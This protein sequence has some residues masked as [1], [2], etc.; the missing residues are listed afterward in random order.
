MK[1]ETLNEFIVLTD[2][3]NYSLASDYLFISQSALT[4]HIQQLEQ[5]LGVNLIDRSK[6]SFSL[7]LDGIVFYEYALKIVKLKQDAISRIS[8]SSDSATSHLNIGTGYLSSNEHAILSTAFCAFSAVHPHCSIR[9]I[10]FSTFSHCKSLLR[11]GD[12]S[13]AILKYSNNAVLSSLT[14]EQSY[15]Y[16]LTPLYHSPLVAVL[17]RNH[18]LS[19]M[20]I[21]ITE[22]ANEPFILGAQNTF[23]H[24]DCIATCLSAGFEPHIAHTLD[25]PESALAFVAQGKGV[26]IMPEALIK[27]KA[28]GLQIYTTHFD[29]PIWEQTSILSTRACTSDTIEKH[30]IASILSALKENIFPGEYV[31]N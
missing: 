11:S 8:A 28:D 9:T 5:E 3:K 26:S 27:N 15:K 30:F 19:G 4:K 23:R 12:I 7:T 29:P 22:L 13:I 21:S 1:I 17:P 18:H 16:E 10:R 25:T 31:C 14:D 20:R 6:N 2:C 24:H